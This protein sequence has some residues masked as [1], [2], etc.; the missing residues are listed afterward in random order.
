VRRH[1]MVAR[2]DLRGRIKLSRQYRFTTCHQ[3]NAGLNE[4]LVRSEFTV[5]S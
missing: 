1:D 3:S 5:P 2:F 4:R